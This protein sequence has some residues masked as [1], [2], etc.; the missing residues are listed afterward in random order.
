MD[1]IK[2]WQWNGKECTI[3]VTVIVD[4]NDYKCI[5]YLISN[6]PRHTG[7]KHQECHGGLITETERNH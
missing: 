6:C 7:E 2:K 3:T 1:M 4:I 5:N